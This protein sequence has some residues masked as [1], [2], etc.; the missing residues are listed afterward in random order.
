MVRR[1]RRSRFCLAFFCSGKLGSRGCSHSQTDCGWRDG[2]H[3]AYLWLRYL[4]GGCY[5]SLIEL[6][7]FSSTP[8]WRTAAMRSAIGLHDAASEVGSVDGRSSLRGCVRMGDFKTKGPAEAGST[9]INNYSCGFAGRLS[10]AVRESHLGLPCVYSSFCLPG[11]SAWR[12]NHLLRAGF[13]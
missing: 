10:H 7:M 5:N 13:Q 12:V 8:V 4:R 11:S 9:S 6:L 2:M 1:P 3:V